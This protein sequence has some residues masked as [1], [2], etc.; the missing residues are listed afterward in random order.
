MTVVR[1]EGDM[2][3]LPTSSSRRLAPPP[4]RNLA[5]PRLVLPPGA[6][7]THFH[8]FG[9][10][11]V[12]PF[13]Q[14]RTFVPDVDHED[15]TI[16]DWLKMQNALGLSR[17]LL[18]QS[19]MYYPS[20]EIVLHGLAREPERLRAVVLPQ[21]AITDAELS[22]L[23]KAGVVGL[24]FTLPTGKTIDERLVKRA[25][26]RGWGMHYLFHSEEHAAAWHTAVLASPGTFIIEHMGNT[27][28]NQGVEGAM[29]R[30]ILECIDTGRCWI[31]LSPRI[32]LQETFPFSDVRPMVDTLLERAPNRLLW[33][34]DWPHPQSWRP[35]PS[36]TDL[37]DQMIDWVP[38]EAARHR[39]FV[40]NPIEVFGFPN[41]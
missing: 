28:I 31:K 36:D 41:V 40:D 3:P 8:F 4:I 9:P 15:S 38:D 1:A 18:V 21:P 37:L 29:F 17:G 25:H 32:S 14:Q 2:A 33:S 13:N 39:I 35:M 20:Y 24:R 26:E 5:K 19:M 12:F 11:A 27:P 22:I 16:D 30:F 23:D 6:C 10:Q 34:S 7:D